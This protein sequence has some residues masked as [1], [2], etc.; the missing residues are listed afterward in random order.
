MEGRP[1]RIVDYFVMVGLGDNISP[2][3]VEQ[4]G[5][6]GEESLQLI[7]PTDVEPITEVTMV[8]KK[9]E[10]VPK[11]FKC[12]EVTPSGSIASL[13]NAGL[14]GSPLFLCYR[15]GGE[16]PPITEISIYSAEHS[17]HY[18]A[19]HETIAVTTGGRSADLSGGGR[20][21]LYLTVKRGFTHGYNSSTAITGLAIILGGKEEPP[22][23]FK[24]L[25][26]PLGRGLINSGVKLCYK[27]SLISPPS[28]AYTA[29]ILSRYPT[30]DHVEFPLPQ[31]VPL[32]CLPFGVSVEA[33]DRHTPFPLPTFSTFALTGAT[34]QCMYGACVVFYETVPSTVIALKDM[35]R[36]LNLSEH[37]SLP[38]MS[39]CI[40]LLSHWPFFAAFKA[41][42]SAL[43][44][45]SISKNI[46]LP[47]ERYIA[48]LIFD[49]P[50]PTS[51]RPRVQMQIGPEKIVFSLP[52]RTPLPMGVSTH[53][54]LLTCLSIEHCITLLHLVLL[55]QKIVLHSSRPALLT[56]V[57]EAIRSILFPLQWQCTYI[58][59]CPLA[60]SSYLQAPVPF[61]IGMD[62][63]YFD[64]YVAPAGVCV[65]DL[66]VNTVTIGH[67]I[68]SYLMSNPLPQKL[69]RLLRKN[70]ALL[71]AEVS[72]LSFGGDFAV[73]VAP[74]DYKDSDK[75]EQERIDVA[76]REVFLKFIAMLLSNYRSCLRP[77]MRQPTHL[78][79][80]SELFDLQQ[81]L[82][83]KHSSERPFY[84]TFADTQTF[85]SFIEQCSFAHAESTALVFF[86]ECTEKLSSDPNVRLLNID[87]TVS[88]SYDLPTIVT[89]PPDESGLIQGKR[90]SY[91]FFPRL[92][93]TLFNSPFSSTTSSHNTS[94]SRSSFQTALVN[95]T[96]RTQ[97]EKTKSKS[98]TERASGSD[99]LWA[100]V[101]LSHACTLWYMLLSHHLRS[102]WNKFEVLSQGLELL[103]ALRIRQALPNDEVC[104]RALME[105]CVQ[106]G[107]PALAVK[108]YSE[109]R[110]TGIHPSAVTYGF[111]N[112]AL[113]EG[114]WP[115]VKRRWNVL[116]I[117]FYAC[118]YLRHLQQQSL[119]D[120]RKMTI[121]SVE[122]KEAN[123]HLLRHSSSQESDFSINALDVGVKG[124]EE[125][126]FMNPESR[127]IYGRLSRGSV[128]RLSSFSK[129]QNSGD[130][131]FRGDSFYIAD[132]SPL[133]KTQEE[134]VQSGQGLL[135]PFQNPSQ[136]VLHMQTH[137]RE[138]G[139]CV[140]VGLYSCSQCPSCSNVIYD[141]E[142]MVCWSEEAEEYNITCPYCNKSCVPSLTVNITKLLPVTSSKTDVNSI[143]KSPSPERIE[144]ET[145]SADVTNTSSSTSLNPIT[146]HDEINEFFELE[147][148]GSNKFCN[149]DP[150]HRKTLSLSSTE[151]SPLCERKLF[152]NFEEE[153]TKTE[154]RLERE[155]NRKRIIERC[156]TIS[157]P[158]RYADKSSFVNNTK[159]SPTSTHQT[160]GSHSIAA[161][162]T[163]A[164]IREYIAMLKARG[165][166]RTTS[167]P[168]P[169]SPPSSF[170][171]RTYKF[172]KD[173]EEEEEKDEAGDDIQEGSLSSGGRMSSSYEVNHG[174][175]FIVPYL[176]PIV[177]RKELESLLTQGKATILNSENFTLEKPIL[178]WNLVWYFTRLHLPTYLPLLTLRRVIK[179]YP[180]LKKQG[181]RMQVETLWDNKF[182]GMRDPLYMIW[183]GKSPSVLQMPSMDSIRRLTRRDSTL[184]LQPLVARMQ[185]GDMQFVLRSLLADRQEERGISHRSTYRQLLFL[186]CL[187]NP[188][189]FDIDLFDREYQ[190]CLQR[191]PKEFAVQLQSWDYP[192]S[193]KASNCR[194]D[195]GLLKVF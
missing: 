97:A 127:K 30:A 76:I 15:Q 42:L 172:V 10:S 111:Y 31:S 184:Q 5:E 41:F 194:K 117:V 152:Q 168:I 48:N 47:L 178:Y 52:V 67:D 109:I 4:I 71:A 64:S 161:E 49:V 119:I 69:T 116:K 175:P 169:S 96:V 173:D 89:P 83:Y 24:P 60:F 85:T 122:E 107:R 180:N 103:E 33:W 81:F 70:L 143:V 156:H 138:D 159:S 192:P 191:L 16:R 2:F 182:S 55:E 61:I 106:L 39:K 118:F 38:Q 185:C 90:Y 35:K 50:F 21:P 93:P 86:D 9:N 120:G 8:S 100:K 171:M 32:F 190:L 167:A 17:R 20:Y 14:F 37:N 66:D 98:L 22:A 29:E 135:L 11:G 105:Q 102:Q 187:L 193:A 160:E 46:S 166:K 114:K 170:N 19:G 26:T 130:Y 151:D 108:V 133:W 113:L 82:Q 23:G 134:P 179:E 142:I 6:T 146:K 59:M 57:G 54:T 88:R 181:V 18:P 128:Y 129:K 147:Q 162:Q 62:S 72:N 110:K 43:Y 163:D 58:P 80:I 65:I 149:S 77:L 153:S 3:K 94:R 44:R 53:W 1:E 87:E 101:L 75:A 188:D 137:N 145:S 99:V 123:F 124:I 95:M 177:L 78:Q 91:P 34:G 74:L 189:T 45:L 36:A 73:E 40:C 155:E 131:A 139:A 28:V 148:T 79:D 157:T 84:K 164:S 126:V 25:P 12:I 7:T 141:E 144:E 186:K 121:V 92:D 56:G 174:D 13:V 140:K 195:F 154:D 125:P 68:K 51:L 112:K 63:R 165:H 158:S 27:T 176:S 132:K 150:V 115:S 104:Y 136:G 183:L